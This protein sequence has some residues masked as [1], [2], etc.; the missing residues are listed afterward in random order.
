MYDSAA[1][2]YK[3]H[4]DHI[5][6]PILVFVTRHI[7]VRYFGESS[8]FDIQEEVIPCALD[9]YSFCLFKVSCAECI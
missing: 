5:N 8:D 2:V 6:A 3:T 4:C 7:Y 1:L 9:T